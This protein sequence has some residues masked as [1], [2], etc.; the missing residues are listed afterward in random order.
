MDLFSFQRLTE[1]RIKTSYWNNKPQHDDAS[2]YIN[3]FFAYPDY[4]KY[5]IYN[6]FYFTIHVQTHL[7]FKIQNRTY[8][9]C[10][11]DMRMCFPS[12]AMK[13]HMF[14]IML[15]CGMNY[16]QNQNIHTKRLTYFEKGRTF[17][18]LAYQFRYNNYA[19]QLKF[20][21]QCSEFQNS[22]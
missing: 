11:L 6:I 4:K 17:G 2:M 15:K 10:T 19:L 18:I 8:F 14:C 1:N 16:S 21:S 5:F 3:N 12:A 20:E 7:P 22:F 13:I 9:G